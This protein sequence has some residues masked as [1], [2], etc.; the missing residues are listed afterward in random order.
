MIEEKTKLIAERDKQ[1]ADYQVKVVE[2]NRKIEQFRNSSSVLNHMISVQRSPTIKTGIGYSE[3]PPPY[4]NNYTYN[5]SNQQSEHVEISQTV[6]I[7]ISTK[8]KEVLKSETVKPSSSVTSSVSSS[9]SSNSDTPSESDEKVEK[10]ELLKRREN[11]NQI[12]K[13]LL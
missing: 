10:V 12:N 6:P 1:I 13:S 7:K 5:P 2:L 8:E 11:I 9:H 3:V 4:N